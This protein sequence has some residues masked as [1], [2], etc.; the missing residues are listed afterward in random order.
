VQRFQNQRE[1]TLEILEDVV[2][3][4]SQH[5]K[6]VGHEPPIAAGIAGGVGVLAAVHFDH[7]ARVATNKISNERTD[8]HLPTKL[9]IRKSPVTESVPKLALGICHA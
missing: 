1:H 6:F 4:E 2:V 9:E 5:K 7:D 8:R 3:P